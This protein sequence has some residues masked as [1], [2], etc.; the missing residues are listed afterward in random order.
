MPKVEL[1]L[2]GSIEIHNNAK[3][4]K[5]LV[6]RKANALVAYLACNPTLHDREGLARLLWDDRDISTAMGNLRVLLN[7]IRGQLVPPIVITRNDIHIERSDDLWVDALHF[8]ALVQPLVEQSPQPTLSPAA[9]PMMLSSTLLN[10]L[11][12]ALTLYRG[13]FLAGFQL[14]E[15]Q[16]FEDWMRLERERY[17]ILA[18]KTFQT[19]VHHYLEQ[20]Q[21]GLGIAT[22]QRWLH[23]DRFNEYAHRLLMELLVLGG[24]RS[25]ALDHYQSYLNKLTIEGLE[26]AASLVALHQQIERDR[27]TEQA[28]TLLPTEPTALGSN[29]AATQMIPHNLP[30]ALMPLIGR[31]PELT[32]IQTRLADPACR[33]LTIVGL[34]GVGKTHLAIEAAHQLAAAES[35]Y[36]TFADGIYLVRLDGTEP[37]QGLT[38]TIAN[39]INFTFQGALDQK[40]Q[41][42]RH[43]RGRHMLLL[44][45]NFEHLIHHSDF[46]DELLQQAPHLKILVTSRERLNFMG[47]WLLQIEGLPCPPPPDEQPQSNESATS[48]EP[49]TADLLDLALDRQAEARQLL[50]HE[51]PAPQL[52]I[53]TAKALRPDFVPTTEREAITEICERVEGL[54]LGIQLAAAAVH[55]HS[56]QE[57]ADAIQHNLDF[58]NTNVRNL[59]TRHRGLRAAFEHSR[60]MLT[61]DEE[62]AFASLAVFEDGF[63]AKAAQT[64]AAVA[65]ATLTQLL[66]KSLIQRLET[67][68]EA[69]SNQPRQRYRLHPILHHYAN[70]LLESSTVDIAKLREQHSLYFCDFAAARESA[71]GNMNAREAANAIATELENIRVSWR[72]ALVHAASERLQAML[73][74]LIRFY[75]LRG[76]LQDALGMLKTAIE[77]VSDWPST[78]Q[79]QNTPT[80]G[81]RQSLLASLFVHRVEIATELGQYEQ[82]G[83]A[84]QRALEYAKQA[85]DRISEA[86]SYLRWGTALNY[87]G[88]YRQAE[89]ILTLALQLA[90]KDELAQIEAL[91]QHQLGVNSFYRGDYA[92]GRKQHEAA[93]HYYQQSGNLFQELRTYHSLAMLHFYTGDYSQAQAHYGRCLSAYQAIGDRPATALT[94]NNLGALSMQLGDYTSASH[95]FEAA[96]TIRRQIGDRQMEGL[97]LANLGLLM[98]LRNDQHQASAYCKQALEV[99]LEIEERDTEAYSRTC[100]AH[101]QLELGQISDA[102]ANYELAV[103]IRQAAGQATQMLEPMAGLARTYLR[104][105]DPKRAQEWVEKIL[106]NL[107]IH[108][109]AG[110][111]ELIRIYLTCYQVLYLAEDERAT[112]LLMMGYST[113]QTRATQLEDRELRQLYLE[114]VTAH[115]ELLTEYEI[116]LG[117]R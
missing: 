23:F 83:V 25:A 36:N 51:Y 44:L 22:A 71:L 94:L 66:N 60:Q 38:T 12:H 53:Q 26:P 19:L 57:I 75:L 69:V 47:E 100:L 99:S 9:Q 95:S 116:R 103:D 80:T 93:I 56:C 64:V 76:Y 49:A 52:F 43:L 70:Q 117:D 74:A 78:A 115:R 113:L 20:R 91:V 50:W 21:Y 81:Q 106:P 114:N 102:I 2:F 67:T 35:I 87:H 18:V 8:E 27:L 90:R 24:Q 17:Q 96:L 62:N 7:S 1:R 41:L 79:E 34:G 77:T 72:H 73:P 107:N 10:N 89:Q 59:P 5:G 112:Q 14:R 39:A 85:G 32:T 55:T 105:R 86:W 28:K 97:I 63:A 33:L 111:V 54:P 61:P 88:D 108:T 15:A 45:D 46:L 109:Y 101:A 13:E 6:S 16:Q 48:A 92:S 30:S 65:E 84:A 98:H 37:E 104:L 31:G 82:A 58:I 3:P 40:A 42:F 29:T 110:I 4:V 11:E 68:D